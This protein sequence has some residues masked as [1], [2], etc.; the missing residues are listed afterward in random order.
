MAEQISPLK[1][2]SAMIPIIAGIS[3]F[4]WAIESRYASAADLANIQQQFTMQ[5]VQLQTDRYE[6]KVIEYETKINAGVKLTP[7]ETSVYNRYKEKLS[8]NE[9]LQKDIAVGKVRSLSEVRNLQ[10]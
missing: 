5:V 1:L 7:Y 6:E 10:K 8:M 4:L 2:L 9:Q 3:G